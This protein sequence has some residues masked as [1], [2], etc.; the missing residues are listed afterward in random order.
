MNSLFTL[1]RLRLARRREQH[2]G[3]RGPLCE[4]CWMD[5][6]NSAAQC[7]LCKPH[8][9]SPPERCVCKNP[10]KSRR[11][12]NEPKIFS[13]TIF[14]EGNVPVPRPL[15]LSR[16]A[17]LWKFALQ[18]TWS[19]NLVELR[20]KCVAPMIWGDFYSER[21]VIRIQNKPLLFEFYPKKIE[22]HSLMTP[23]L[24]AGKINGATLGWL[25]SEEADCDAVSDFTG[26]ATDSN[27][28]QLTSANASWQQSHPFVL[29]D[30]SG[31]KSRLVKGAGFR[32]ISINPSWQLCGSG[33]RW[34]WLT[35]KCSI[36][37]T[38]ESVTKHRCENQVACFSGP[39]WK[40]LCLLSTTWIADETNHKSVGQ[41]IK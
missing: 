6:I 28:H 14:S 4:R 5:V 9:A 24:P 19:Q 12:T 13:P 33:L 39:T 32:L 17:D 30:L 1:I 22:S 8:H 31:I 2:K 15:S 36:V 34:S 21:C 38:A 10:A 40:M 7:G 16:P 27:R 37:R 29:K 20:R 3:R 26:T 23:L 18:S 11:F 41:Q 25:K 35:Q